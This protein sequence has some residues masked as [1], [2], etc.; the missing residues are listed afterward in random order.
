[1]V[2]PKPYIKFVA[3]MHGDEPSG[4]QV[5]LQ[6]AEWMCRGYPSD[7]VVARLVDNFHVMILPSLNPDGFDKHSRGNSRGKVSEWSIDRC[8]LWGALSFYFTPLPPP[9]GL[10]FLIIIF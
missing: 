10:P 1:M 3:N 9:S 6:W 2:E 4:R 8:L 5:L 7:P